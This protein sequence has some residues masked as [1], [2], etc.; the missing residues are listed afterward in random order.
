MSLLFHTSLHFVKCGLLL[1]ETMLL[2]ELGTSLLRFTAS[3]HALYRIEHDPEVY[4]VN[5]ANVS[6][7]T[8]APIET[9]DCSN[10]CAV[11]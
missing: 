2:V 11:W 6:T 1:V 9:L 7:S 10:Y 3:T 5:L 4:R 8:L